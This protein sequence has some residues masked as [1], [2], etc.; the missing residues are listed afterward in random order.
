M[1]ETR[2]GVNNAID[3][4]LMQE[5]IALAIQRNNGKPLEHTEHRTVDEG[6]ACILV[7]A[8]NPDFQG[9]YTMTAAV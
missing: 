3:D 4:D 8:L 6:C 5:G 9:I 7:A 2:F 1:S